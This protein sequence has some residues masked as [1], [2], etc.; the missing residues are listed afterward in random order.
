MQ[1]WEA[2]VGFLEDGRTE[3]EMFVI[4]EKPEKC[5]NLEFKGKTTDKD[6]KK[7]ENDI[8][9][10][11]FDTKNKMLWQEKLDPQKEPLRPLSMM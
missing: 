7:R 5:M 8:Q 3:R 2:L 1:K 4:N 11:H 10:R 9:S 6:T